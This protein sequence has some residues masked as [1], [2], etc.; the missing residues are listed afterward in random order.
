MIDAK[1]RVLKQLPVGT[2]GVIDTL[3]PGPA[4]PPPYALYGNR[5]LAALLVLALVLGRLILWFG[6]RDPVG[7]V[8]YTDLELR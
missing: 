2:R 6:R 7:T 4:S 5:I 8:S 3:L 1:G